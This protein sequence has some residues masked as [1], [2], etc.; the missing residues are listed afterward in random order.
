M[1][2]KGEGRGGAALL[3]LLPCRS[4]RLASFGGGK[5]PMGAAAAS[6]AARLLML[7]PASLSQLRWL[8][9]TGSLMGKVI[10]SPPPPFS[11]SFF[12]PLPSWPTLL[13]KLR[14][15]VAIHPMFYF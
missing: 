8:L 2:G 12:S 14:K 6:S 9:G 10:C 13:R 7:V 5:W 4:C 15:I 1:G 3:G 11:F